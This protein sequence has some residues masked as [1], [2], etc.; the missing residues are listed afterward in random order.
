M[1]KSLFLLV[2][3]INI[4][5][6][7]TTKTTDSCDNHA[8]GKSYLAVYSHFQFLSPETTAGFGNDRMHTSDDTMGGALQFTL[9]GSHSTKGDAL[10]RYF[11]PE[12]KESLIVAE[13][14]NDQNHDLLAQHFNIFTI[15][16]NF[17]STI[18]IKPKQTVIGLGLQYKQ[19]FLRNEE[20]ERGFW[21]TVS[22]PITHVRNHL[23]LKETVLANGGGPNAAADENVVGNMIAAFNQKEWKFGK[24][25]THSLKKT[26]L[27][28]IS[29]TLGYEWF[30]N[31][32]C[33]FYS[34]IVIPTGNRPNGEFVFQPII[35]RGKHAAFMLGSSTSRHLWINDQ[36]NRSVRYEIAVHGEYQFKKEQTRSFDLK[37]KPWSRYIEVYANQQQAQQA[38]QLSLTDFTK[39]TNL[40]TPGIN[41]FTQKVDVKPG[42]AYTINTAL[43]TQ[44]THFHGTIGYNLLSKRAECVQLAS[45]WKEGPAIKHKDGAGQTNPLR[46]ISGKFEQ[47]ATSS[48]QATVPAT[49]QTVP[50]GVPAG[51]QIPL[52]QNDI[53]IPVTVAN[54]STSIIKEKDLDLDSA[55]TPCLLAHTLYG[56]CGWSND[57]HNYPVYAHFGASYTFSPHNNAVVNHVTIWGKCGFSF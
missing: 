37:N 31:N 13:D 54:Y 5:I 17:R 36:K 56:S 2:L 33:S 23:H 27:A 41:V 18:S 51:Q 40:A 53:I 44:S 20:R 49:N 35:G 4:A 46:D 24:I 26:G 7:I 3:F 57:I 15:N 34:G 50:P 1:K 10:A 42:C 22:A 45:P 9:F 38:E 21:V 16:E 11:F 52:D 30:N 28:D 39:G 12:G 55:S 32:P 48:T 43:I 47:F 19:S 6:H 29:V 25:T 8:T 14:F